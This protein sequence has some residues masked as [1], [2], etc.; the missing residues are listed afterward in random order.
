[1]PVFRWGNPLHTFQDLE[2]EM[3][4][5]VRTM[6]LAF[7]G[8]RLGRPFPA[9]NVFETADQYI[10]TAEVP[11]CDGKDL[12]IHVADGAMT[13][14]GTRSTGTDVPEEKFRRSERPTGAWERSISLPERVNE[15]QIRAE[16]NHGL[17][18]VHLPKLPA[19]APRQI[20]VTE[21]HNVI[22]TRP[23]AE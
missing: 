10:I 3:D 8:L 15:D 21:H 14:R 1:M 12:E 5:W 18:K 19:T 2:R 20:Q 11:G 16:L 9:L 17:L 22:P 7:E 4:R 6:D 13:L 23:E